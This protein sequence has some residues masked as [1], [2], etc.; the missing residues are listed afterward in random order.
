VPQILID[1]ER[2]KG[3]EQ[4][5]QA[6]P[7]HILALAAEINTGGYTFA[8]VAEPRRCIGCRT[9]CIACPDLAIQ[10]RVTGTLYHYFA[11]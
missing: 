8:Q 4:C 6:C 5:V 2:C 1:R 3:C 9:C 10:M 11:Y 7:Q